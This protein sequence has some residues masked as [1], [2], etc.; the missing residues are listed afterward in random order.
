MRLRRERKGFGLQFA[1]AD[2]EYAAVLEVEKQ[3]AATAV[4][5]DEVAEDV[6]DKDDNLERIMMRRVRVQAVATLQNA[7]FFWGLKSEAQVD[8][9]WVRNFLKRVSLALGVIGL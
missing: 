2:A 1:A 3:L 7:Q 6:C 5:H 4:V 9:E 8:D